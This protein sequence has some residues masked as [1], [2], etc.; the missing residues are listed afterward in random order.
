MLNCNS[1]SI[2]APIEFDTF[3]IKYTGLI[4]LLSELAEQTL[5]A[6]NFRF[7]GCSLWI[8]NLPKLCLQKLDG[9]EGVLKNFMALNT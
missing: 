9:L 8:G 7:R 1:H 3:L 2:F 5:K 4:L 6:L